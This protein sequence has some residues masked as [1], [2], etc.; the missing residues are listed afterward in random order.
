MPAGDGSGPRGMGPMT[1][2]GT[3]YCAGYGAPGY[4]NP[5]PGRGMGMGWGRG[6]AWG[7]G[8]GWRH[9]YYATGQPGWARYGYGPAW[10]PPPPA[11]YGP[12]GAAPTREQETD[13]LKSQAE[14][15]KQELDAISQRITELEQ[16]K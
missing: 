10:G 8:R 12:Y 2:R 11:A 15:L 4:A 6:G 13:F 14:M 9:M 7:R 16:E 3:G 1:G 5:V